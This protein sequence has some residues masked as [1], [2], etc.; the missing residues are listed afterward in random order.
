MA[1]TK[2]DI[3]AISDLMDVK[4]QPVHSRLDNVDSRLDVMERRFDAMDSRLDTMDCRFDRVESRLDRLEFDVSGLKLGQ[5]E[6]R[7]TLKELDCKVSDTYQLA[8]DAWGTSTEN[9]VWLEKAR[10][11]RKNIKK[12]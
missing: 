4:L 9:R 6:I 5:R 11:R 8:L 1:L 7:N 3:Q 12:S 10:R 2:E